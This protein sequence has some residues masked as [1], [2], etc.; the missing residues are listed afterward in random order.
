VLRRTSPAPGRRRKHRW[1]PAVPIISLLAVAVLIAGALVISGLPG[2]RD[3]AK[4]LS[5]APGPSAAAG[6]PAEAFPPSN[7]PRPDPAKLAAA[8]RRPLADP[9]F[10]GP[11]E[12]EVRDLTSGTVLF[13]QAPGMPQA[14]ASTAKLLL[15]AVAL[16]ELGPQTRF[17]TS[18]YLVGS[19][20]Y[21]VGG[22]DPTL[23]RGSGGGRSPAP[24]SVGDLAR[25]IKAAHVGKA[26][27]VVA[28][29][30]LF[31][32]PALAVGWPRYY[33]NSQIAPVSA[34][35]VDEG[36]ST[37]G[38]EQVPRAA[39]P[40]LTAAGA[41]RDALTSAGVRTGP[42]RQGRVPAGARLI[43]HVSSP[44]L[45]AL[46]EHM[47]T[48]SDNDL[49]EALGR[50]LAHANGRSTDFAG[51]A[52]SIL[53]GLQQLHMPVA[54]VQMHDSSGLSPDDRV[55]PAL[56]VDVLRM[57]ADPGHPELHPI[58]AGLPV[59]GRTGTLATRYHAAD[60]Q[61]GIGVVRAKSGR[62]LGINALAGLV[63]TRDRRTL[64]FALRAP[65]SSLSGGEHAMDLVATTIARCGCR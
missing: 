53:A 2:D 14:P 6:P 58:I 52:A 48:Y 27:A 19:T 47:L 38:V 10:A 54:G 63:V 42:V 28:D 18:A 49:A 43:A 25:Q 55:P 13:A 5:G 57:A 64:I 35:T 12:L 37:A 26:D 44:P 24:A 62:L 4:I 7:A 1:S 65:T 15:S 9:G 50:L 61:A 32:G 3:P 45:S 17:Q 33:L 40:D 30:G 22:G 23:T 31:T 39:S 16:T 11:A 56:L 60:T 36:R 59:A 51:A 8:L 41:L 21:L 20:I 46:V 29:A 34:L